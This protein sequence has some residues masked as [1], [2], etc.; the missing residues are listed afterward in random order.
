MI[1]QAESSRKGAILELK[2]ESKL[3]QRMDAIVR[4]LDALHVEKPVNATNTFPIES[5]YVCA[6]PTHQA[7]NC[8]SMIVFAEME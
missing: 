7:Q 8:L 2:G 6:S 4:R 1:N 3:T 5:C